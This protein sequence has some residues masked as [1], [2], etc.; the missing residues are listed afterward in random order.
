LTTQ[1][2]QQ[3][4]ATSFLHV[5]PFYSDND[6]RVHSVAPS[7]FLLSFNI[8]LTFC[9]NGQIVKST[10]DFHLYKNGSMKTTNDETKRKPAGEFCVDRILTQQ[11]TTTE[12]STAVFVSRYCIDDP[13][14]QNKTMGCVHK[15]C[16]NGMAL[17][18]TERIC[19][20]SSVPFE[21]PF[22]HDDDAQLLMESQMVVRDGVFVDCQHGAY[23]LRPSLEPDDEFYIRADGRL[24][25]PALGDEY[26]DDYCIDHFVSQDLVVRLPSAKGFHLT[27]NSLIRADIIGF[28]GIGLFPSAIG[29]NSRECRDTFHL[30]VFLV[31][32]VFIS[33]CHVR[34]SRLA[35][36]IAQHPRYHLNSYL[37]YKFEEMNFTVAF[38]KNRSDGDVSCR[39]HDRHVHRSGDN[40][41]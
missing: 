29:G 11:Q 31:C 37:D 6:G 32:I 26:N 16:P 27:I 5:P 33:H 36:R 4:Y 30:S 9:P 2:V 19:Q 17:N 22:H 35:S 24:H 3:H 40:S 1:E 34:R 18:E 14:A 23:P 7:A 10:T 15:C 41:T 38:K 20:P 39:L 28:A 25:A 21:I 12:H 13:C 8:N